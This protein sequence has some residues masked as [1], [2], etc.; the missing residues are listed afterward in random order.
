M[1]LQIEVVGTHQQLQ[2][3]LRLDRELR[4]AHLSSSILELV[5]AVLNCL[6]GKNGGAEGGSSDH[7]EVNVS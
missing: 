7:E 3:N 2:R 6:R 4:N 5:V 1:T